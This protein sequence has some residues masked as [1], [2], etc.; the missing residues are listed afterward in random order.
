MNNNIRKNMF[1]PETKINETHVHIN[2][3]DCPKSGWPINKKT[4]ADSKTKDR[5]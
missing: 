1:T 4:I 3:I 2:N 5:I